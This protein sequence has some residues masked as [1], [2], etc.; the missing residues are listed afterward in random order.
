M[1]LS[2]VGIIIDYFHHSTPEHL[3]VLGVD[4]T[5]LFEPDKWRERYASE[6]GQPIEKR[7][8]LL[9]AWEMDG[10]IVGFS[11]A[12]KITYGKQAN[13]HL[14]VVDPEHRRRG[15]GAACVKE[16]ASIYFERLKLE[17]LFCEPNAFNVAP[18][19][20]LQNAGF[21]YV[22]TH[23]TVPGLLNFHQPVTRWVMEKEWLRS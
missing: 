4:P 23:E 18:N 12:D 21:K 14:H 15:I 9:V 3:N 13:M 2:E 7:K 10:Q 22:K 20:T 19:R 11:T 8:A 16:S 5:R 17:R 1:L 6:Y